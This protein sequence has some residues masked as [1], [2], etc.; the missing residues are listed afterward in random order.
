MIKVTEGFALPCEIPCD[1]GLRHPDYYVIFWERRIL[2]GVSPE[3]RLRRVYRL[4]GCSS[5]AE[6]IEWEES[7]ADGRESATLLPAPNDDGSEERLFLLHGSYSHEAEV[8]PEGLFGW[9]LHG[10]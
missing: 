8:D 2:N 7:H 1:E 3:Y 9:E 10:P 5:V 6:A 4:A